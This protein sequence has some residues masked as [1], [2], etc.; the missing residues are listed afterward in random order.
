MPRP[1]PLPPAARLAI[2]VAPALLALLAPARAADDPKPE[3]DLG[4]LQGRWYANV[5]P[6]DS[7]RILILEMKGDVATVTAPAPGGAEPVS[8]SKLK[9]AESRRP[10]A[11]SI[12]ETK[13]ADGQAIPDIPA[14]YELEGDTLKICYGTPGTPEPPAKFETAGQGDAATILFTYRRLKPGEDPPQP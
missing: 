6:P 12:V 8:T 7:P 11:M 9:L 1:R 2:V 10:R 13:T 5:G 3:G 14:I 4:K